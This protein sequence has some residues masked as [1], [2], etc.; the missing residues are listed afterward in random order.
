MENASK[1]IIIAGGVLIS[2][3][4]ISIF[5]FVFGRIGNL[6]GDTRRKCK[7]KRINCI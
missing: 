4:T 3:I 5:Y 7:A 6:A 2:M 1:A